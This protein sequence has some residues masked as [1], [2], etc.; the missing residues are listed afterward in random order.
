[1]ITV[2]LRD[3][4]WRAKRLVGGAL[5]TALVFAMTLLLGALHDSFL[6]ETDRTVAL[7]G[8]DQWVVASGIAG[9]FTTNTPMSTDL[10]SRVRAVPG[11]RDVSAVAIFR[12]VV[13]G[14]AA[15]GVT[16][17]NVIGYEPGSTVDLPVVSGRAPAAEGEVAVDESLGVPIGSVL[18]LAGRSLRVVGIVRGVTYNG[19]TPTVLVPLKVAQS[20][21][22]D[23]RRLASAL[24]VSGNPTS[25][26][27]GLTAMTPLEIRDDLRRPLQVATRSLGLLSVLLWFVAAGIVGFICYLSGLDRAHDVAVLKAIGVGTW[28]LALGLLAMGV[29]I[30]MAAAAVAIAPAAALVPSFPMSIELGV[31]SCLTL[32]ALALVTGSIASIAGMLHVVR[33]DPVVALS[34]S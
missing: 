13:T 18:T 28:P 29:A 16:D 19:G 9:P 10:E 32:L 2:V 27:E 31:R 30:A 4:Q 26:P 3:M 25:L 1:M 20:V 8:A 23:G 33:T 15:T 24:I 7:F 21:A 5:A 17:V 12:H 22:F 34:R 14:T 11:V 6:D